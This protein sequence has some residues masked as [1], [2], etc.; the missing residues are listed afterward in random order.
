[1]YARQLRQIDV[2]CG[3]G[4]IAHDVHVF[5][6]RVGVWGKREWQALQT[7]GRVA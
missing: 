2:V 3:T 1:M 6:G 4:V 5:G 7:A